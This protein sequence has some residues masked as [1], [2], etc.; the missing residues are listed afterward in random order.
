MKNLR[1]KL[2][3]KKRGQPKGVSGLD[4][5]IRFVEPTNKAY[6]GKISE[7]K[8]MEYEPQICSIMARE[9]IKVKGVKAD[10][11][12]HMPDYSTETRWLLKEV[13]AKKVEEAVNEELASRRYN[14]ELSEIVYNVLNDNQKPLAYGLTRSVKEK[15]A[16]LI[17]EA[18]NGK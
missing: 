15:L 4:S 18:L 8:M 16:H 1:T 7:L 17:I 11:A 12:G 5:K 2:L 9:R 13:I 3:S 10:E 14:K 6:D